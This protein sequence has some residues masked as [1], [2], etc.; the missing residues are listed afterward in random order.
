MESLRA[1]RIGGTLKSRPGKSTNIFNIFKKPWKNSPSI[2]PTCLILV[3]VVLDQVSACPHH[4][5]VKSCAVCGLCILLFKNILSSLYS[6]IFVRNKLFLTKMWEYNIYTALILVRICSSSLY[7][8]SSSSFLEEEGDEASFLEEEGGDDADAFRHDPVAHACST[9]ENRVV[10]QDGTKLGPPRANDK[11][12]KELGRDVRLR[13]WLPSCARH[14]GRARCPKSFPYMCAN[15]VDAGLIGEDPEAE[16]LCRKTKDE[17]D[18]G[19]VTP[20]GSCPVFANG[21]PVKP[22]QDFAKVYGCKT[23]DEG[24]KVTPDGVGLLSNSAEEFVL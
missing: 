12:A 8:F 4:F 6:D 20:V 10:C 21:P 17:C 23:C 16:R 2:C 24:F 11:L 9:T 3:S 22:N 15:V 19:G 7:P 18:L 13:D 1:G 5:C 14:Q